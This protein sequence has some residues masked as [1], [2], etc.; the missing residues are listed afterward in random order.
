MKRSTKKLMALGLAAVTAL[1]LTAC[2]GGG[3]TAETASAEAAAGNASEAA[4]ETK[5]DGDQDLL[6]QPEGW[7]EKD[8]TESVVYM[9]GTA[10]TTLDKWSTSAMDTTFMFNYLTFDGLFNK[11]EN[12]QTIPWLAESYEMSDDHSQ[13]TLHLRDDVYFTNGE[14]LTADDVVFSFERLRDD[15]EHL[16]DSIVKGWRN[17]LGEMEKVDDHTVIMHFTQPM[18]EF[19]S[20]ANI[21]DTQIL[22]KSAFEAVPYEEF[23]KAPVGSGPYVV[24]SFDGANSIVELDLR[25]DEHGYWGYDA[26]DTYTNV[27]HITIKQSPES[28]T[29]VSSLRTGEADIIM[30][31]PTMDIEN[32]K[33][34]GFTIG[35]MPASTQ[36]FLQMACAPG[37]KLDNKDLREA[38]SLCIDRELIVS[39]LLEGYGIPAKGM[40][41]EGD[42]G[43][44]D[45]I[46]Y[47]YN[48]D[49]AKELVEKSGYDGT[50]L[51][52]IYSPSTV[53]IAPEM[54][55]AIQ[56]MASSI[57][58]NIEVTPL[59]TAIYDE[60]R[61]NHE[62]DLCIASIGKSGNMWYKT[63]AEVIGND[64]F[65]TGHDNEELKALGHELASEMDEEKQD[66]IFA[67][68]N[69]IQLT[70]FEPNLYLYS[71]RIQV[72]S[73][74]KI[75][76][77]RYHK[78]MDIS[79]LVKTNE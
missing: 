17:Y 1:S 29:R 38:L 56:S 10:I 23:W 57:G 4:A 43:Y 69:R 61:T 35:Q 58:I 47:E 16:P 65:N 73:S 12:E 31:P 45:D 2:G 78:N 36:V 18:P 14:P 30:Q 72:G 42:I 44:R 24:S 50:P 52:L 27:K 26:T 13:I 28:T 21:P 77:I 51:K 19:W 32:L 79:A 71:P 46:Q 48:P 6:K 33:N 5:T 67:E 39:A 11:D 8:A 62:Y 63:G 25:T 74:A 75:H 49:K 3:Q 59:E 55:Q 70:E 76:G 53:S 60:A 68:M 37:D 15:K 66:E 54:S 41:V 7:T 34:E 22:C 64:R 40:M 9:T 20:M